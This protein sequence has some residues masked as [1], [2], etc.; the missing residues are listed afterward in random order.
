MPDFLVLASM[1][2]LH[3]KALAML[4]NALKQIRW[5]LRSSD[6][7]RETPCASAHLS[8]A[9]IALRKSSKWHPARD[10]GWTVRVT[11]FWEINLWDGWSQFWITLLPSTCYSTF[12][13]AAL[14]FFPA[15]L[16]AGTETA[17]VL[18]S[19]GFA[20]SPCNYHQLFN[21]GLN[22][23]LGHQSIFSWHST[24]TGRWKK[25]IFLTLQLS[26][27]FQWL[28]LSPP[29]RG[30]FCPASCRSDR[31]CWAPGH[32]WAGLVP[33]NTTTDN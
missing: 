5:A 32:C 16:S 27:I 22:S 3:L 19:A 13:L 24:G 15:T 18:G 8:Q 17:E 28:Y 11:L 30:E 21:H 2:K 1:A 33:K 7:V 23:D 12:F 10:F 14:P 9:Q 6:G 4:G 26:Y 29:P 25:Q 20:Q 31:V